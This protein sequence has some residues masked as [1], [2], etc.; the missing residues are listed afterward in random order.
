MVLNFSED[1]ILENEKVKLVPLKLD[2][3]KDLIEFAKDKTIWTYFFEHGRNIIALKKYIKSALKNKALEK[4]Y[5]FVIYSKFHNK[6][7]GT[8]RFYEYSSFLKTIKLG[9][10]WIGT[11]FQGIRL[12]KN[13]KFLLFE[14]AFEYLQVERIGFG[15]YDSN[16]KSINALKSVGCEQEGILRGMFPNLSDNSKRADA[17]L[18]S[19]LREE[20]INS[21][22]EKL[23]NKLI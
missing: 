17:I 2:H 20:W 19:I 12:N 5:P 13:I 4:E 3:A 8:T 21:K 16:I 7:I 22:K 23:K 1:Y 15:V 18:M 10:S 6:Y 9:H 11:S 14:F